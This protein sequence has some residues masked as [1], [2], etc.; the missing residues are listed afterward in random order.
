[1]AEA[2]RFTKAGW[3]ELLEQVGSGKLS[4]VDR[5][6]QVYAKYHHERLD[7]R[8]PRGGGPKYLERPLFENY[9]D[10]LARVARALLD[11]NPEREMAECMEALNTSMSARAPIE[12]NNLR[13]SG[14]PRVF[15]QGRKVYDRAAWQRRL[16]REELRMLRRRRRIP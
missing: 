5:V 4:G 15:S 9:Q 16:S 2:R 8:H 6:D 11:G 7:L 12:F 3:R 1:V 14:N 10:Y 13:R